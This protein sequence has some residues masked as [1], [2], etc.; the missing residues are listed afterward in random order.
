VL[1]FVQAGHVDLARVK[2]MLEED[3]Q[4]A[5]ATWD[6]GQGDW[7]TAL[8]GASHVGRRDIAE[9]LLSKGA[10]IDS[11][12]AAMLGER[13]VLAALLRANPSVATTKGPHGYSLL[14]HAAISG[15]IVIAQALKPL[16]EPNAKDYN[17]ALSAAARGGHLEMTHWL[18][19]NGVT[20][21]NVPDGLGKTAL[22]FATEKNYPDLAAELRNHGAHPRS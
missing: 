16:I 1:R 22:D 12:C 14:Y 17:Q 8:G 4:F 6:W 15:D 11:F 3:P 13:E 7:E 10:R 5:I 20:N 2:A 19:G 21:P 18:L 9:C